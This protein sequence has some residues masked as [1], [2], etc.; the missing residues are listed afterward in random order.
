MNIAVCVKQVPATDS[1]I[2]P[3]AVGDDIERSGISYVLNPYD[4]FAV[5]AAL[6]VKE[7]VKTG[8]VTVITLAPAAGIEIL[9][10]CLAVGADNAIHLKDPAFAYGDTYATAVVLTAA[11]KQGAYDMILFGKQAI[12]DDSAAVG[13]YV[14]EWM[15]LPHVSVMTQLT[16][17]PDFKTAVVHRQIEGGVEVVETPLPVVL[18]CQKGLNDPRYATLPGIMKAKQKPV[19][20]LTALDIGLT[21]EQVGILGSKLILERLEPPQARPT[22]TIL[23]GDPD[24]TVTELIRLLREEAKVI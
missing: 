17:A 13:I 16:L 11:L 22:G 18:T 8:S 6:R 24:T 3:N 12:D 19:T 15:G 7:Q 2:K 5:E 14:A 9:R 4:E 10:S 21:A 23:E 20:V 1:I